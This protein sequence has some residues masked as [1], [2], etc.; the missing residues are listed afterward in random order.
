M[1][2]FLTLSNEID[3]NPILFVFVSKA[4]RDGKSQKRNDIHDTIVLQTNHF[5]AKKMNFAVL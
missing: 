2:T 3:L 4:F 5:F 1:K